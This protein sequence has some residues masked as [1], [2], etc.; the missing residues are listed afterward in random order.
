[1]NDDLLWEDEVKRALRTAAPSVGEPDRGDLKQDALLAI[2]QA[3]KTI[4]SSD[5]AYSLAVAAIKDA[6]RKTD[7][8]V[9]I[10][11]PGVAYE[12]E[13]RTSSSDATIDILAVREVVADLEHDFPEEYFVI[14][15]LFGIGCEPMTEREVAEVMKRSPSW[16][17]G[18][19]QSGLHIL[20]EKMRVE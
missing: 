3:G 4:R 18:R 15:A 10:N 6:V 12:A 20:R 7:K 13:L 17:H 1:M 19:K 9:S 11:D 14:S 2:L 16:V 5:Q 8:T